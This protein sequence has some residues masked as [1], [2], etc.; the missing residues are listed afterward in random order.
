MFIDAYSEFCKGIVQMV[1]YDHFMRI[2]THHGASWRKEEFLFEM[3]M[4][5]PSKESTIINKWIEN[6][7]GEEK[8]I[9]Y[10]KKPLPDYN[11][12]EEEVGSFDH[13]KEE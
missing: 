12:Y 2:M 8:T 5:E 9:Y 7:E 3:R 4:T 1:G 10:S 13:Y 11:V 6:V